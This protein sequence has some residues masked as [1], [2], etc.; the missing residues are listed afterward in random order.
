LFLCQSRKVWYHRCE[1]LEA[2]ILSLLQEAVMD[3]Y[4]GVVEGAAGKIL[5]DERLR[6]NL[7]DDEANLLVNWAVGWLESRVAGARDEAAARASA[8]AEV[9]RLRP[10]MSKINALLVTG[11]TPTAADVA[12]ALG[13]PASRATSQALLDRKALIQTLTA[14][15][16]EEWSK[17]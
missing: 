7:T 3:R 15:L 12:L 2:Q 1:V 5:E 16:T 9:A 13:L 10:A 14:Q 4:D 6:G 11:K 8:L 17:R